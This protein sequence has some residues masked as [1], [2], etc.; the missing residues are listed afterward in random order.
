MEHV[1][2]YKLIKE[3]QHGFL[4]SRSCLTNL[5]QFLG[6][7]TNY[8]DEGCPI[9]VINLDFQIAFNRTSLKRLMTKGIAGEV[10]IWIQDWLKDR[11]QRA[12]L[13]VSN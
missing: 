2:K 7:V 6:Y 5:L 10:F 9:D 13:L 11:E 8:I 12:V 4:K 3:S 1:S